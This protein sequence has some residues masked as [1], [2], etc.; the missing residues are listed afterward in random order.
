MSIIRIKA[1]LVIF[2]GL[3]ACSSSG[4]DGALVADVAEFDARPSMLAML[5]PE[6]T[7]K[8]QLLS[9]DTANIQPSFFTIGHRGAPLGIAEHTREGYLAAADQGAG[10]IECD[11]TFTKDRE[12]VCRHSQCDLHSSTNILDTAL[13]GQCRVPPDFSSAT[14]FSNVECCTTDITLS[15]F[16]SLRG[17]RDGG[18]QRAATVEQYFA[19]SPGWLEDSDSNFAELMTHKESIALF[20]SLGV[21][22][23]PELKQA[24]VSMPF[25][26]DYTQEMYAAQMLNDYVDAGIDT[27]RVYPQS[28]NLSD[29]RFWIQT[30]PSFGQ[31][32]VYLD[33]RY[34]NSTFNIEDAAS[35]SPSM[36]ELV[37]DGVEYLASPIW[38]LVTLDSQQEIVASS[39]ARAAANAGLKLIA[40]TVERGGS[41]IDGN[42][43]YYQSV[44][45]AIDSE[46]DVFRVIDVLAKDVEVAGIFS[47]WPATVSYYSHCVD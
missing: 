1:S 12:L 35:W 29:I 46:G 26:G 20:D 13:A 15:E 2:F 41:I 23:V 34:R 21:A 9:C 37:A 18:D 44:Q 4:G 43:W 27:A 17:K 19:G 6:S 14:P 16:K 45:S 8:N 38:M 47:D 31:Q 40:W 5:L 42:N 32:A 36:N 11:V 25:E 30:M 33:G 3:V 22:M 10:A 7:L 39:Y 28:F 24:E